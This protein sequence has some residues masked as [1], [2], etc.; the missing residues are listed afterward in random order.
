[1]AREGEWL[2]FPD[3]P[4]I[5]VPPPG[6]R[7]RALLAEQAKLETDA[8]GYPHY[9]PIAPR[10]AQGST[11]EDVDGNRFIDWVSG[12]SVLNLGHRHPRLVAALEA[13][14][15]QIWHA[16][17]LPTEARIRF[18]R[19]L[20]EALP[21]GLR[22]HARI[23]LTVTGGDA[24]ETAVNLADH[25]QGRHGTVVFSGAYHGV[26]G[27]AANLTS[28]RRYRA[29]NAFPGGAVIRVPYPDPY[30]PVLGADEG[31][32][33]TISYLEHLLGD[34]HSGVDAVSSILVE[35]I[36]GE[37]GY[38]VPPDD[39][40]PSLREFCD[41]HDLL[42]VVD[43]VQTGLGRTGRMWAVDHANVTPDIICLAKTIGGGLPLSVVA[44]RSDLVRE[45]PR[46]F[47]LG[48]YRGNPLALAVG[49]ETLKILGEG[50]LLDRTR[51][52]GARVLERLRTLSGRH[53][54]L[55]D[56]R[57]RG[58]MI[59]AEFVRDRKS[60]KAWG[61]RAKAMRAA[62]L[63]R[64]VLMHTAGAWDQVLRFMAP[65]VIEDELL[66]RGLMAFEE[67]LE[68]LETG[69]EVARSSGRLG[70]RSGAGEL[71]RPPEHAAPVP[72]VPPIPGP[73]LENASDSVTRA[74]HTRSHAPREP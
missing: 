71:R 56:V 24:V 63:A 42:L 26:H 74:T 22:G 64:G 49:A 72:G 44:Y 47:H 28:G 62:L 7:S 19:A 16:L 40:L 43:E 2:S 31:A 41:R 60:R 33:G 66:E 51:H 61:E 50:D 10:V 3:A 45:L 14:A 59:G 32:A 29:P 21:G 30:R 57:G 67:A 34:P 15:K 6:P 36:L 13:Q 53:P 39:F 46:G 55:G 11:I 48:T 37:G 12:I 68:S 58:F 18:L 23:F 35:P 38:V 27:G 25:A 52:R 73:T 20:E 4:K 8:V 17:E 69:P 5:V 1:M 65:L 9:F 54:T 70:P